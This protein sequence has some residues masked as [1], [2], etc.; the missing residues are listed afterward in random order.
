MNKTTVVLAAVVFALVGTLVSTPLAHA[1]ATTSTTSTSAPFSQEV[2]VPCAN[3]GQGEFIVISG[4]LHSLIVFTIDNNGGVTGKTQNQP[5]GATATGSITGDKYQGVGVTMSM[6]NS[7][8]AQ[9]QSSI[10]NFR[11]IGQGP[12]NNFLL[13]LNFHLTVNPDGTVTSFVDNISVECR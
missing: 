7:K 11:M 1:A 8:V 3:D 13:H 5:Q 6:F 12:D 9:E 10:N 2:F 4:T